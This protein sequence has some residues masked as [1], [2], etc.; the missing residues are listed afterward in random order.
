MLKNR[1]CPECHSDMRKVYL[2]KDAGKWKC[3]NCGFKDKDLRD[4]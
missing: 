1:S 4:Y 2:G 3:D